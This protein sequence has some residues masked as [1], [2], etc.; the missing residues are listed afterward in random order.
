MMDNKNQPLKGT[1]VID[2]TQFLSGPF[3]TMQLSD[4]GAE[5]IK[6]ERPERSL[7]AGPYVKGERTYDLS[8]MRGKK[9]I[10]LNLKDP[11]EEEMCM[12]LIRKA[13]IL[14]E[15]FKPGTMERMG[16]GYERVKQENPRLIYTSISG[17]GQTGPYSKRGALD[18][19]IQGMSGFMSITGERD[20]RPM[21]AG[22]SIA[23]LVSGLY[24]FGA[25]QTALLQRERTGEGQRID[26]GMMDCMY[27]CLDNAVVN[28]FAT[29]N[30]TKRNGTRHQI[31]TPFQTY[32]AKDGEVIFAVNRDLAYQRF[33]KALNRPDLATDPRFIKAEDRRT[34]TED[35]E[36]EIEKTTT[37]YTVDE[38]EAIMLEHDIPFGRINN[39][40]QVSADP[41]ILHRGMVVEAQH[42]HCG[43]YKM[44]GNPLHFSSIDV[45]ANRPAPMHGQH[46]YEIL[47]RFFGMNKQQADE[48][49][50]AQQANAAAEKA[51]AKARKKAAEK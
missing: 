33:C 20:G 28:Y 42:P 46:N 16:L 51:A 6:I 40:A 43:P 1:I 37:Q 44:A 38:L 15:N 3:C 35:M 29:G 26:I 14:V 47:E 23:D 2:F 36:I 27:S 7:G 24:A 22:P 21:K 32:R 13:D 49:L 18:V 31:N 45:V 4:L 19:V 48:F 41:Q 9:S 30:I 25:V 12:E 39:I 50:D 34:Y 11:K 8:I 10:T 17:F 5:V